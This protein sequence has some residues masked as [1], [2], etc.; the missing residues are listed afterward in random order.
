MQTFTIERTTAASPQRVLSALID[1][2]LWSGRGAEAAPTD[3]GLQVS[4][5]ITAADLSPAAA[6][7]LPSDSAIS[8][9]ISADSLPAD[10][11]RGTGLIVATVPGDAARV[12]VDVT[13]AAV[14][15]GSLVE[16]VAE[17]RS[18]VPLLGPKIE[19]AAAS[20]LRS[21]L[22]ARLDEVIDL[23]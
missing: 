11:Q 3:A 2:S 15:S 10:A 18:S 19:S 9:D 16:A 13:A 21:V 6:K 1:P 23:L 20:K 4:V 22:E 8:L 14:G 12:R 7:L 5:P 17:V